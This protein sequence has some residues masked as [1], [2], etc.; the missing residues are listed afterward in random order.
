MVIYLFVFV[1]S[2][3]NNKLLLAN[4]AIY[5]ELLL[6]CTLP[7]TKLNA[8]KFSRQPRGAMMCESTA[9]LKHLK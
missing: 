7:E 8:T 5:A 6:I 3:I 4:S 2:T 1:L 9:S